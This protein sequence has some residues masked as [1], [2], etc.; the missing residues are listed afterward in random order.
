MTP[1]AAA[2]PAGPIRVLSALLEARTGQQLSPARTWRVEALLK[3]VLRETGLAT[4]EL[5]AGHLLSADDKVLTT[6]VVEALL[7]NET[8]FYRDIAAFDQ[9][10]RDVLEVLRE[11]NAATRRLRIWSAACSTGQEAYSI[12]MMVRDGGAR[13]AGWTV[14]IL[15]SDISAQVVDRARQGRFSR[16]EIQRGL[17][18]RTMLRWFREDGEEWVADPSLARG[19]RFRVHDLRD[20]APGR[21]DLILCRNVLMYF[22]LPVRRVALGHLAEALDP[23]GLVILGAGETV[24]GQTEQLAPHPTIRG[25][26]VT[27]NTVQRVVSHPTRS[28]GAL[29]SVRARQG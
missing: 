9:I 8:S 5:L 18:V 11:R 17:P 25:V 15:A 6:R 29:V 16:F 10:D 27:A 2:P 1:A 21:F 12:A 4:L 20:A 24:L 23:G 7:N 14:D 13:W 22:S 28:T 19:I 26:Y 3:P